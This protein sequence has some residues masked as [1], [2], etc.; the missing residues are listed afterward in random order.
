ML[1]IALAAADAQQV[2]AHL[3]VPGEPAELAAGAVA[4]HSLEQGAKREGGGELPS[5]PVM[6]ECVRVVACACVLCG[7]LVPV[8]G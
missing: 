8:A 2:V 5:P 1:P 6:D 3:V 4:E 7:W